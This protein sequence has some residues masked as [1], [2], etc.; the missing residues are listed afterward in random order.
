MSELVGVMEEAERSSVSKILKIST[1]IDNLC[2]E[3]V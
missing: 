2:S 1:V 3:R